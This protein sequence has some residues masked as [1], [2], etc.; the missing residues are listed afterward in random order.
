MAGRVRSQSLVATLCFVEKTGSE[1][2]YTLLVKSASTAAALGLHLEPSTL[3]RCVGD[4]EVVQVQRA[5]WMLYCI[6]KSFALRVQTFSVSSK[7]VSICN[8]RGLAELT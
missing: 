8:T 7:P 4:D 6:E 1:M 5:M 3:H 2:T